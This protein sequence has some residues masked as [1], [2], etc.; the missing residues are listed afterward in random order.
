MSL[1]LLILVL[2]GTVDFARVFYTAQA[3]TNAARAGTLYGSQ[4]TAYSADIS[5]M[6]TAAQNSAQPDIGTVTVTPTTLCECAKNDGNAFR[7]VSCTA[8]CDADE[9]LTVAAIVTA[10]K[11]FTTATDFPGIPHSVALT[12]TTKLRAR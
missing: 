10:S 4:N 11:T 8:A 9:H 7:T 2:I 12:R 3:L 5:G 6:R 1:P